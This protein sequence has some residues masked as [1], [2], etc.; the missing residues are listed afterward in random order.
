MVIVSFDSAM[1]FEPREVK[2]VR[3][4]VIY[5]Q[6]PLPLQYNN[7]VGYWREM[8]TDSRLAARAVI[9]KRCSEKVGERRWKCWGPLEW[10]NGGPTG[11]MRFNLR[12][13]SSCPRAKIIIN[14]LITGLSWLVY[15]YLTWQGLLARNL[16]KR[17][18]GP[19]QQ[20]LS[21]A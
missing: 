10:H 21:R 6:A 8:D 7:I 9:R 16:D 11:P 2:E 5:F 18:V 4:G 19:G 12:V 1:A 13:P 20:P 14:S 17:A 3:N 15:P